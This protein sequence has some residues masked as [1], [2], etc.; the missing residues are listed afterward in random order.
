M[1][2][3]LIT[4][5]AA[6][7]VTLAD[8]Q[9]FLRLEANSPP[10]AE[11][12][13]VEGFITAARMWAEG[14][15]NRALIDQTW[16]LTLPE[17]PEAEITLPMGRA[18]AVVSIAYIDGDGTGQALS[19]P[20]AS[21]PGADFRANTDS[22]QGGIVLPL[23]GEVWPETREDEPAAVTVTYRAGYGAAGTDVPE[24]IRMAILYRVADLYEHRGSQ[25]GD[26]TGIAHQALQPYALRAF[27]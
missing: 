5:P 22:D 24:P 4:P 8:A 19:G 13:L 2:Q 12:T 3:R 7:P 21:P 6:E 26:W 15:T 27:A 10:T 9:T 16:Q 14:V 11:D 17:F 25:D 20:G 18:L 23:W 1:A